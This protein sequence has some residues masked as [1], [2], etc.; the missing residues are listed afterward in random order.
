MTSYEVK[1][2]GKICNSENGIFIQLEDEFIP[3]LTAL[4]GFSHINVLWWFS[5]FDSKECRSILDTEQPYKRAPEKMGIFA[6]RSPIRPNP[7]ALTAVEVI[8][9]DYQKGII[10]IP[11]IDAND[12]TPVLDIKPYTP[13]LDRIE[14]PTV[15]DWC[16]HW[17]KSLE[18]SATFPWENEFNF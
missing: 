9:I 7:I 12:N 17:P 4:E 14:N 18:E 13:S 10:R 2:I 11:Y 6:T 16:S 8:S 5:E 3:A 1:P 15:P